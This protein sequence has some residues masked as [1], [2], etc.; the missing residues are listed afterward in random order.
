MKGGVNDGEGWIKK[1]VVIVMGEME[2][3]MLIMS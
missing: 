2:I 3:V 1:M